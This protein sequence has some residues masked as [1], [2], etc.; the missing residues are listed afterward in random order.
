MTNYIFE[1]IGL[2]SLQTHTF[3]YLSRWQYAPIFWMETLMI[4]CDEPIYNF[5]K[6]SFF[7]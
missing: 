4:F 7:N 2:A 1:V 6:P 5:Q 3:G